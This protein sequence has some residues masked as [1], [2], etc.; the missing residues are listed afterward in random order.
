[1]KK[2][3]TQELRAIALEDQAVAC[4]RESLTDIERIAHEGAQT[5]DDRL[6]K[7]VFNFMAGYLY[8]HKET[9]L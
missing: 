5:E 2:K 9:A 1:M 4:L 7:C 6:V 3:S 8:Y